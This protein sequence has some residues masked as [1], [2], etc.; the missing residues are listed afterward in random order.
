MHAVN[1]IAH[2]IP[3]AE[4]APIE[5]EISERTCCVTGEVCP[6]IPRKAA[7]GPAFTNADLLRAPSSRWVSVDAFLA[8]SYKWERMSSWICDGE[9]FT[10]LD[11]Q[12][13]RAAVFAD[14]PARPWAAYATTS[15]KKHGSLWAPV[16][17]GSRRVWR[18]EQA[19]VDLSDGGFRA[20]Y[21]ELCAWQ[22]RGVSR[23]NMETLM[24]CT[25]DIQRIGAAEWVEFSHWAERRMKSPAY[26]FMCYLL[27][28]QKELAENADLSD[29]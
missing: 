1:L 7:L 8:L 25:A 28:S 22:K 10:R 15:Y 5:F 29:R 23:S 16:N 24:P 19:T 21:G 13:V 11:R 4:C 14:V 3:Q 18:F 9:T 12:G 6:C 17:S 26:R 27:P 20:L 2:A